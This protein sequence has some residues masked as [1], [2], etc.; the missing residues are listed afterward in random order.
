M[1]WL[2]IL[3]SML[4]DVLVIIT[5]YDEEEINKKCTCKVGTEIYLLIEINE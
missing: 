3:S 4:G 2:K 5:K 1:S